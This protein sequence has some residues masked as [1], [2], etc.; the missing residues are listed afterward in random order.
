MARFWKGRKNPT[1]WITN[2]GARPNPV[3]P[4]GGQTE[5]TVPPAY[6]MPR[7]DDFSAIIGDVHDT[8]LEWLAQAPTAKVFDEVASP[9]PTSS[10]LGR[11]AA[12][13]RTRRAEYDSITGTLRV[14]FRDGTYDYDGITPEQWDE[15]QRVNSNDRGSIG[16]WLARQGLGGL[17]SGTRVS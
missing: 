11:G 9:L 13:A 8:D 5:F 6:H 16:K 12:R 15:L 1:S 14:T 3:V 10:M 4:G 2:R 17:G 7:Q